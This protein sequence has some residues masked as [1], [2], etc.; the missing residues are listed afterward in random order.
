M[1]LTRHTIT[2]GVATLALALTASPALAKGGGDGVA[3]GTSGVVTFISP[4]AAALIAANSANGGGGSG[5][6]G[7]NRPS[8]CRPTGEITPFGSV[9]MVC[10]QNRV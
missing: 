10:T 2:A 7:S 6:G 9:V 5:N 3:D 8:T 4:E 1:N